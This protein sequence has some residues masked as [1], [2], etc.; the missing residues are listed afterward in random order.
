[1]SESKTIN[2]RVFSE[3]D[4]SSLICLAHITLI[5]LQRQ[6]HISRTTIPVNLTQLRVQ[7]NIH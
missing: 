6:K 3:T 4:I 5:W 7:V 1:M 2:Y